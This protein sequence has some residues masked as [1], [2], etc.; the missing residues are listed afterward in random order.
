MSDTIRPNGQ[1]LYTG[2]PLPVY[3]FLTPCHSST[4]LV[5]MVVVFLTE[6]A[7]WTQVA[8]VEIV[9]HALQLVMPSATAQQVS[10]ASTIVSM[11]LYHCSCVITMIFEIRCKGTSKLNNVFLCR[12]K[13]YQKIVSFSS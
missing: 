3:F 1:R 12:W 8:V 13:F 2:C 7:D 6:S 5:E 9:R 10:N 4:V 11:I